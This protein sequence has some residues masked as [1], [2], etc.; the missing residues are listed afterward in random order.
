LGK[1]EQGNSQFDKCALTKA[2]TSRR[3]SEHIKTVEP[4]PNV[5]LSPQPSHMC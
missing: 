5:G 3:S 2:A 1:H 4:G